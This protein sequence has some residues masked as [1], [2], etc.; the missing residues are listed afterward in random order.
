M[1]SEF[2]S[3]GCL[4]K[5]GAIFKSSYSLTQISI[6]RKVSDRFTEKLRKYNYL[7]TYLA[8]DQN[9][10]FLKRC[11]EIFLHVGLFNELGKL[12][13]YIIVLL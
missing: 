10:Q 12:S 11:A 1:K 5:T 2:N 7:Q 8:L 9:L 6:E 3:H 13:E 4:L